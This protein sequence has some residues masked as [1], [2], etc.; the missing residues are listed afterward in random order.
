MAH[1]DKG[2]TDAEFQLVNEA[3]SVLGDATKR[4]VYDRVSTQTK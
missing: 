3:W 2:G 1:P 4:A